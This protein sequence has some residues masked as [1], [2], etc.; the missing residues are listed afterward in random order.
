MKTS[1]SAVLSRVLQSTRLMAAWRRAHRHHV[2]ILMVHGTADPGRPSG[3]TPLRRQHSPGEIDQALTVLSR[4]YRFLSLADAVEILAGRR[5]PL[6]HGLVL[7]F[8]DGYRSNIQ[9]ALPIL[10]KHQVPMTVFLTVNH[11]EQRE[12]FWF[13][14]MDYAIQHVPLEGR[15]IS[16]GDVVVGGCA[17]RRTQ[18][19]EFFQRLRKAVKNG[20][21]D[22]RHFLKN[23][24]R[25]C[26][27]LERESGRSLQGIFE[28]DPWSS[29]LTW[30]EVLA[31]AA[32]GVQFGSHCLEHF[33][34]GLLDPEEERRQLCQSREIIAKRLGS[35]RF[36]AYPNGSYQIRTEQSAHRCGYEAALTTEEGL[37]APGCNLMTLKRIPFPRGRNEAELLFHACGLSGTL[38]LTRL[39]D[40]CCPDKRSRAMRYGG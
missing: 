9:D 21:A 29:V 23:L 17:Q 5:A 1:R 22:E 33:R 40:R 18:Q 39:A 8:D 10:R 36:L 13:D 14:R 26:E 7:T 31:A 34:L 32:D 6:E 2:T 3:W 35:C 24:N 4:H 16:V 11:V 19:E 30:E 25:V 12:P 37:N 28:Q 27:A 38:S 15:E 20:P